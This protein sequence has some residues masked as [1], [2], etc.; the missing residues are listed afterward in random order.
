MADLPEETTAERIRREISELEAAAHNEALRLCSK[1]RAPSEPAPSVE[2]VHKRRT[3]IERQVRAL[4]RRLAIL[5]SSASQA[6]ESSR[7]LA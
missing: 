3:A 4:R 7:P 5:Q 6:K 2:E 1:F